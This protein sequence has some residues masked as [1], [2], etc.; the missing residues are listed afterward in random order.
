MNLNSFYFLQ[1]GGLGD[2]GGI[3]PLL[4]MIPVFYFFLLRPQLKRQKEEKKYQKEIKLGSWAV[5]SGG[6][7]GR[8]SETSEHTITLETSAGKI[9]MEKSSLSAELSKARYGQKETARKK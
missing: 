4:L 1:I 6:L 7:H 2:F 5:T 9:K 3:L 8:I